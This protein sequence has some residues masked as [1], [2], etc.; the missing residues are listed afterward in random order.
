MRLAPDGWLDSAR[1][2]P[3]P[4]FDARPAGV[5]VDLIVLHNISLPPGEF[6]GPAIEALFT[7][8]L[9][10]SAHPFFARLLGVRLSS[11]LLI[12]RDGELVQFVPLDR[13]TPPAGG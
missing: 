5:A 10:C 1:R 8:S 12:R 11:H 7:N 13:R 6:G 3:S 9:D 2:V 4:N